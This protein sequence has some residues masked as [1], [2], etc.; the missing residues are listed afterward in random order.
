MDNIDEQI[1]RLLQHDGRLTQREI[2]EQVGLST[3]AAGQRVKR[4]LR[5]G[6]ITGVHAAIDHTRFGRPIEASLDVW[7]DTP[8]DPEVMYAFVR[9]DPR[10]TECFHTTGVFDF[11]LRARLAST[12]D[13]RDLLVCL[14]RDAGARQT[15]SRIVLEQIPTQ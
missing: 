7:L 11:Q 6:Y 12:D 13:L 9:E 3:P 8:Q 10:I 1:V 15:E 4:L 2:G 5:D 14:K